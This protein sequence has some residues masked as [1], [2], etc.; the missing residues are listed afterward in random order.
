M[1]LVLPS[2]LERR[3]SSYR[4]LRVGS[5][6]LLLGNVIDSILYNV[7]VLL[8]VHQI[9]IYKSSSSN[10]TLCPSASNSSVNPVLKLNRLDTS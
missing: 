5:G 3:I 6:S 7:W 8:L 4:S 1:G 2:G 9:S 10:Q